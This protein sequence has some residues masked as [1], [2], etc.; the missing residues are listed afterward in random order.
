MELL[1]QNLPGTEG[2]DFSKKVWIYQ[3]PKGRNYLDRTY[4]EL[5]GWTSAKKVWI[6]LDLKGPNYLDRT[7]LELKG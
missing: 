5:K 3:D 1:E 7:Y 6:Y 2:L 4:F